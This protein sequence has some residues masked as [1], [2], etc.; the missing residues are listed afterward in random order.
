MKG[1]RYTVQRLSRASADGGA[2]GADN[3]VA[4]CEAVV[5]WP[6]PCSWQSKSTVLS[7]VGQKEERG[8]QSGG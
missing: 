2:T 5:V 4:H 6:S 8:K 1:W 7:G 3:L